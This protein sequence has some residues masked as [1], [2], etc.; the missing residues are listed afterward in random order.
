METLAIVLFQD[1]RF[2]LAEG[3]RKQA[4]WLAQALNDKYQVTVYARGSGLGK[5]ERVVEGIKIIDLPR[6]R[7]WIAADIIH[8]VGCPNP[9]MAVLLRRSRCKKLFVSI[10]DGAL[11]RFWESW[12]SRLALKDLKRSAS[13][14]FVQ[15]RHQQAI[16]ERFFAPGQ[17]AILPPLIP[18]L[19]RKGPKA[20][21]PTLL[22]MSHLSPHK[23]IHEVLKAY[24]DL[25]AKGG[26]MTLVI[27]DSGVHQRPKDIDARIRMINLQG[28]NIVLKGVVDPA[29]E[30]SKAWLYLYPVRSEHNTFSVPLSLVEAAQAGTPFVSSDVAGISEYFERE[31]LV[32]ELSAQ[33]LT[34]K[35][36]ALLRSRQRPKLK[37]P[38]NNEKTIAE[39]VRQYSS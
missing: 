34:Q 36:I 30:L 33:A 17:V 24:A 28:G 2:P 22:F 23:G 35:I 19:K 3:L 25:I 39:L 21:R 8:V 10:F 9:D 13:R 31:F 6:W 14:I 27:A 7:Y 20:K 18:H 38:I 11:C 15:T 12:F 29:V 26:K 37:I 32:H 1:L 5:R 16:A 4:W